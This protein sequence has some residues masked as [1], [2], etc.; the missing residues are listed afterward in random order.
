MNTITCETPRGSIPL[1]AL[2]GR[3]VVSARTGERL[4][5][6][7]GVLLNLTDQR[8]A[9]FRLRHG[10]LLGRRWRVAAMG[11]VLAVTD[12]AIVLAD[13]VA[14]REDERPPPARLSGGHRMAVIDADGVTVGSL[15]DARADPESQDL[16]ELTVAPG[17][18]GMRGPRPP[19]RVPMAWVRGG[20][21]RT[22]VLCD[23]IARL[24]RASADPHGPVQEGQGDSDDARPLGPTHRTPLTAAAAHPDP[25][26]SHPGR[27]ANVRR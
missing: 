11:D 24:E 27:D 15:V 20:D 25:G 10:S 22:I 5:R 7:G 2:L 8:L 17:H 23:P 14:L 1:Q 12:R 19:V 6:V 4:G 13:D 3:P 26:A 18:R 21:H 16:L 9:G